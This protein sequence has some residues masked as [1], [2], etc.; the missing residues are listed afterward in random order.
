MRRFFF[1]LFVFVFFSLQFLTF[2]MPS[3]V[4]GYYTNMPASIVIGQTDFLST[5]SGVAA[6]KFASNLFVHGILVDSMGRLI[7]SDTNNNRVLIWNHIPTTNGASAD[8]VLGQPDFASNTANNGGISASTL[9]S[10]RA[11]ASD[12]NR[13]FVLDAFNNRVLIWNTLPTRNQQ[14]AD[15]VVGQAIMSDAT[16]R[17]SQDGLVT[18]PL[19]MTVYNNKLIVS[20]G[21]NP[22]TPNRVLIWNS[23]PTANG[24]SADV[25]LGQPDFS[26]CGLSSTAANTFHFPAGLVVDQNGRLYLAD[27]LNHRVLIWNSIPTTNNANADIVVGQPDFTSNSLATTASGLQNPN[28]VFTY[29]NRLFVADG[30]NRR[31]LIFNSL[32]TTNGASADIVVGQPDFVTAGNGDTSASRFFFV[33]SIYVY[34]NQMFVGDS[35]NSRVLI[36]NNVIDTPQMNI[37]LPLEKIDDKHLRVQG[38][39]QLGDRP[40]YSMQWVKAEVNGQGLGYVTSLGGGRDN[41]TNNTLYDFFHEF[42]PGNTVGS[43]TNNYTLKLVASSFNADTTSLFYF[44]PFNFKSLTKV[45]NNLNF[46]FFVNKQQIQKI[47]DNVD[48]FEIQTSTDSGKMWKKYSTNILTDKINA[49]TGQVYATISNTL[50]S[51]I[52]YWVRIIAVSRDSNWQEPSNMLNYFVPRR[53]VK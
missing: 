45:K 27:D 6:D 31:V 22:V 21:S 1:A 37:N 43:D 16:S 33:H 24:A 2:I 36:F 12:G 14:P 19:G 20:N 26:T 39:I 9:S 47:K 30:T 32:P 40:N 51:G 44:L 35:T 41:G 25:V 5:T 11:V 3:Q 46:D 17:C 53:V 18:F 7:I 28:E 52:K 38:N 48:H 13:F 4:Y 29:G 42:S 34:N 10:P 8:L 15:V 49:N 50:L 23:I